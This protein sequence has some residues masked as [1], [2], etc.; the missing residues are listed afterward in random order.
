MYTLNISIT[1]NRFNFLNVLHVSSILLHFLGYRLH[2]VA[3][4]ETKKYDC[5]PGTVRYF[6]SNIIRY[7]IPPTQNPL[8]LL[9]RLDKCFYFIFH[10]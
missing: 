3:I 4:V 5:S 6:I 1:C 10:L 7:K 9:Y 8:G 2:F